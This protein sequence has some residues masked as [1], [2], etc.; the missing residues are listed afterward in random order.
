MWAKGT[1]S[2][3]INGTTP[4]SGET[5]NGWTYYEA[6][7]QGTTFVTI[8]GAAIIDELRLFPI[9]AEMTSYTYHVGWGITSLTDPNNQTIYYEYDSLGRLKVIKDS[10]GNIVKAIN[11]HYK[12]TDSSSTQN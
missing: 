3:T 7:I 9:G 8:S 1:G 5:K 10:N 2:I 6:L 4:L 12:S 11:Y